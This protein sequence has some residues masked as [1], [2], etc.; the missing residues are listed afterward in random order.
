M[1]TMQLL[2]KCSGPFE[3]NEPQTVIYDSFILISSLILF[4]LKMIVS[5]IFSFTQI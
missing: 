2:P 1:G 4:L 3:A 5:K